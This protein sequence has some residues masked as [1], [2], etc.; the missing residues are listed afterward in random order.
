[1]AAGGSLLSSKRGKLSWSA[2]AGLPW[3]VVAV[4]RE[5][6]VLDRVHIGVDVPVR[7]RPEAAIASPEEVEQD[8]LS[9]LERDPAPPP[10]ATPTSTGGLVGPS[11]QEPTSEEVAAAPPPGPGRGIGLATRDLVAGAAEHDLDDPGRK[12]GRARQDGGD[13]E[14]SRLHRGAAPEAAGR[15]LRDHGRTG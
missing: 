1:M 11:W 10:V 12:D 3:R 7:D 6:P 9:D 14:R 13:D 15:G 2:A 4:G 5:L 8:L